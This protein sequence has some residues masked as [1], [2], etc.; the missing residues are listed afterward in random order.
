MKRHCRLGFVVLAALAC[1]SLM[2]AEWRQFRGPGGLATSSETG[3]PVVW[4]S[5]ENIVWKTP[6][7]GPGTSSPVTT[8]NRVFVTC[9]T[10]YA[11]DA[12]KPGN[13]EDL[14]RHL[15]CVNRSNG[16]IL[17]TKEF[18]PLLPE[19][20][21]QGEGSYH[22][23]SSSTPIIEGDRLYVFFGKSGVFCFD[24]DGNQLW[25]ASVGDRIHDRWGSA[26]S[27]LLYKSFLIVNASI[28]S[29][30]LVALDKSTG[31]EVWRARGISSAWNTPMLVTAPDG[32]IELIVSIQNRVLAFNPDTGKELWNADGVHRYVC[33]SVVFND[34]I[35][36]A[37]GGG[38]T[39]LAVRAG[40]RGDVTKSNE[41]WRQSRG[42]NVSSP[43]YHDGHI[44]WASDNGGVVNCQDAATG[45]FLYQERLKPDSG[46]IY[47][48]P[49][50]A[51]GK[52]YYVSQ[53]KGSYVVAA[54]PEFK[55]LAHNV[56]ADDGS[57]ANASPAVS[58]GQ[59][60]LRTDKCLYCIAAK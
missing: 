23:Y 8:G 27:P 31:N 57:R 19:H 25:H 2:G 36:Y 24:L 49:V 14:K 12:A 32:Q 48:S 38:H 58:N 30:C 6:L 28:E 50:L 17:W 18:Q 42:S 53:R 59:L 43:I 29:G 44:Y 33:P 39:S 56:F 55:L 34:G 46:L 35:V 54:S 26:A 47:A 9:Y 13:M 4:S 16:K 15:L 52:I 11:V 37:I 3:L 22:G 1:C 60:L 21:Y 41:M 5:T 45:K 40:G 10:G 51:D 7:P 20:K